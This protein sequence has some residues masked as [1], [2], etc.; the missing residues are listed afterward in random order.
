MPDNELT[1]RP[2]TEADVPLLLDF[3]RAIAEYEKLLHEVVATET[4]VRSSFFGEGA[5]AESVIAEL[6]GEPAA[7][8]VFFHNFSTFKGRRGLYLEDLFVK[9]EFRRLGIGKKLLVHLARI[10]VERDCA[11]FEWVALD[12]NEPA[13]KFYGELGAEIMDDWRIFRMSGEAMKKLAG[14]SG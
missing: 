5:V 4:G 12:W 1:M 10:A 11:R 9:P 13:N 7:F 8:A 6:D 3:I 14:Q 2:A